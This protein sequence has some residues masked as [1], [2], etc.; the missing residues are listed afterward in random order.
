V[1]DDPAAELERGLRLNRL[2]EAI[3]ESKRLQR[4]IQRRTA[5][6]KR[7]LKKAEGL[8]AAARRAS[9]FKPG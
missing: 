3:E 2:R 6:L 8:K 7:L 4:E 5:D 9:D 1:N